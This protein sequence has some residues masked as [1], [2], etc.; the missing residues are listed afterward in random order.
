MHGKP[1]V[2]ASPSRTRRAATW[3][4]VL[5][6]IAGVGYYFFAG[7]ADQGG[8][9]ARG[10]FTPDGPVPVLAVAAKR[11]DVPIYLDAVGTARA[12]NTVTVRPQ[13]DGKLLSIN[14]QEG[15]NVK[16]GEVLAKIDPTT[17]QAALDQALA[18]KAQDE[19][20]L[21]NSKNDLER[22]ERLAATNAIN[23]QQADTQRALVAQHAALVQA[24]QAGYRTGAL[25]CE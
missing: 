7:S 8:R 16:K 15:E 24:D 17:F 2:K 1:P 18:K 13:V 9:A 10:R 11:T 12:L 5:L 6:V 20:Q 25:G 22:Y 23:R 19:A 21:A 14:F 4:L 3:T